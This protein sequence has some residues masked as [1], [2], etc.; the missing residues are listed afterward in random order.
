MACAMQATCIS[1]RHAKLA[2]A[3]RANEHKVCKSSIPK[4]LKLLGYRR[5]LNRK[6]LESS[7]NPTVTPRSSTSTPLSL[8]HRRPV[9][10]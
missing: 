6:T 3:L 2:A 5:Q 8:P 10:R 9:S 7:R 1:K 4:L